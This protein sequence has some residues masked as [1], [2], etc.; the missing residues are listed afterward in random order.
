MNRKLLITAIVAVIV[1]YGMYHLLSSPNQ[2]NNQVPKPI[3]KTIAPVAPITGGYHAGFPEGSKVNSGATQAAG[4][5]SHTSDPSNNQTTSVVATDKDYGKEPNHGLSDKDLISMYTSQIVQNPKDGNAYYQRA[6]IYQ[7]LNHFNAAIAD[8]TKA[9]AITPESA[10]AYYNRGLCFEKR[11][12]HDDA[13]RDFN[14][15]LV[16]KNDD[17]RIYNARGLSLVEKGNFSGAE[18][19][20]KKAIQ[21]DPNYQQ[22]YFNLGTLY[23]RDKKPMEALEQYTKAIQFAVPNKDP[24]DPTDELQALQHR[25]EAHYRRAIMHLNLNQLDLALKDVNYVIE[26]DPKNSKAFRLRA[27]IYT[28]AGNPGAAASDEVTAQNLG[29]EG[30]LNNS[31]SDH[32][33][34]SSK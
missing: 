8:Y 6:L 17:P 26:Q 21:L 24:N 2:N 3:T 5:A 23:E 15:A 9:I 28:K 32:S 20:Y 7:K 18:A 31:R 11:L 25:I 12:E 16:Y 13:I 22:A 14:S 34:G 10:N 27:A 19:D 29:I 4:S 30:M 1:V 33:N